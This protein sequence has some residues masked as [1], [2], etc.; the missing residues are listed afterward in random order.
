MLFTILLPSSYYSKDKYKPNSS[1]SNQTTIIMKNLILI[2]LTAVSLSCCSKDDNKSP[3][4]LPPETHTGANTFGAII[5][6]QIM[7]PRNSIGYIPPG[8][9]HNAVSYTETDNWEEIRASDG[10]TNLGSIYIYIINKDKIAPLKTGNY[11]VDNSNGA[12]SYSLAEN[13]MITAIVYDNTG[14][15]KI[16]LSIAN[17]GTINITRS[18]NNIISGT[19]SCKLRFKDNPNDIIEIKE[20]RFDFNK[21]TIRTTDFT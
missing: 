8:G 15:A 11:D 12:L 4:Q 9:K 10:K 6:R 18:D 21:N 13:I 14:K 5:N 16:Y 2:L 1:T 7:V 20:G 3:N 17:T 19:F